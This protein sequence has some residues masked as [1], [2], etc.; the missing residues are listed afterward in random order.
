LPIQGEK[1]QYRNEV[2]WLDAEANAER[3]SETVSSTSCCCCS[4]ALEH[5]DDALAASVAIAKT[6]E[7]NTI[8]QQHSAGTETKH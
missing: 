4:V 7:N 8:P 1:R 6:F 3:R 5:D 2:L